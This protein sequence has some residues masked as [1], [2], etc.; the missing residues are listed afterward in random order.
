[1]IRDRSLPA[2]ERVRE[3][4]VIRGNYAPISEPAY[5]ANNPIL[6]GEEEVVEPDYLTDAIT[7]EAVDFI[8]RSVDRPFCVVVSYNAVHSPMQAKLEDLESLQRIDDVQRRIFAGMLIALDQSVGRLRE[9]LEGHGLDDD[10][11]VVFFSDNGGPTEELT[12]S[13]RPLRDGKGSVYEGGL[14]VPMVWSMPGRLPERHVEDRPVLSLDVAAT[15]LDLAGLEAVESMDGRSVLGWFNDPA[16]SPLHEDLYWRM[17]GGKAA[18]R[19]GNWKI[20]RP[21]RGAP[22]E[23]YH[24]AGDIGEQRNLA[25]D[26]PS[27]LKELVNKWRATDATMPDALE[28]SQP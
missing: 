19:S 18:Y 17:T 21:K 24:L 7:D 5:D 6:R 11:L 20:V 8:D 27:K 15:A 22:I 1:M 14:R 16:R 10:T 2:G 13:N 28:L 12:S 9:C 3:G 26:H 4:N 23:L 25:S